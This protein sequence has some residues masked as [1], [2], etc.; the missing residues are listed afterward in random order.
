MRCKYCDKRL[1]PNDDE[2]RCPN[3]QTRRCHGRRVFSRIAKFQRHPGWERHRLEIIQCN[4]CGCEQIS[5]QSAGCG[6]SQTYIDGKWRCSSPTNFNHL[7]SPLCLLST[8]C[9]SAR[10][11]PDDCLE[12]TTLRRFRDK[13]ILALPDGDK[14]IASY[15]ELA[16]QL[17]SR[18]DADPDCHVIYEHLWT[19]LVTPCVEKIRSGANIEA[20]KHYIDVFVQLSKQYGL[21]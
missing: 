20:L 2:E 15:Y 16:P 6:C 4:V 13:Y 21:E 12:L 3:K 19:S 7:S 11:L 14:L 9:A 1:G 17:V 18:I 5:S 8:T 10:E